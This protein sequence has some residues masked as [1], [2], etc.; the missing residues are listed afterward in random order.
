MF[1]IIAFLIVLALGLL[2]IEF[3]IAIDELIATSILFS[4]RCTLLHTKIG[5]ARR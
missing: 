4:I 1:R 3:I 2:N 5:C